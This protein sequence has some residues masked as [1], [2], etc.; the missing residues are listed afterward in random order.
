MPAVRRSARLKHR[1]ELQRRTPTYDSLGRQT[2]NADDWT[3]YANR[4][5]EVLEL[6]GREAERAKQIV[7][8][9]SHSCTIRYNGEVTV[10]HRVLF[11][12]R[13]FEIK[14]VVDTDNIRRSQ[15]LLC[16]E[17]K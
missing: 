16:G 17:V 14:A 3:T 7:A 13:V 10:E 4:W 8:D 5:A 9:A 6:S 1:I 12:S 15:I 2:R 11:R